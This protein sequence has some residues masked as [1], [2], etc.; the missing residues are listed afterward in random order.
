MNFPVYGKILETIGAILLAYVAVR[1]GVLEVLVGRHL[2]RTAEEE[3]GTDLERLRAGLKALLER[4]KAQFGL[5]EAIAVS[6][7]TLLIAVGCA[8]Y[9]VG[10]LKEQH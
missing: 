2:R 4:R 8:L 9:L 3:G 7:G 10:L 5:Y 6:A 1:A